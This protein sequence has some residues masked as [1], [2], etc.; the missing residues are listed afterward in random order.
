MLRNLTAGRGSE[1]SA[2]RLL[3]SGSREVPG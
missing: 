2:N 1:F 3:R